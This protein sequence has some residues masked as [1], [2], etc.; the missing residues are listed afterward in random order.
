MAFISYLLAQLMA[1]Y[2]VLVEPFL[3]TNFYRMLKKQLN[4]ESGARILF[5]RTQV[6]WEWSWV[7]VLGVIAISIPQPLQWMGLTLPNL[8]GWVILAALLLGIG[9]STF[10]LQRN[11]RAMAAMQH[12]LEA[13]STLLPTSPR[14]RKWF[15]ATA[16]TAGICEEL[17]YRGF[18]MHYLPSTFPTLDWLTVSILSGIIYGL[19]RA[20]QGLKGM[21][22]TALTGFSFAIVFIIS[23]SLLPAMVFHALAELRTLFLW[24]PEEKTR[25]SK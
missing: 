18:L 13:S 20:Y 12:S 4:V 8:W 11:P 23:G 14:E 6:L 17:L 3:R 21:A 24:H 2:T 5:Y 15:A 7:V 25:K 16:I 19:S 22:Q 9:L 1:A 10:L